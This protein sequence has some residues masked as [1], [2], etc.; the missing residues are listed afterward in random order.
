ME[1]DLKLI[2]Q[3]IENTKKELNKLNKSQPPTKSELHE[4]LKIQLDYKIEL[5]KLDFAYHYLKI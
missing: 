3:E 2:E 1:I 4:L 5:M